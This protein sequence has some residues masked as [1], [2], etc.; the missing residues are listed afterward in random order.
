MD[1]YKSEGFRLVGLA[2]EDAFAPE[3]PS[4]KIPRANR[5]SSGANTPKPRNSSRSSGTR[6]RSGDNVAAA[7]AAAEEVGLKLSSKSGRGPSGLAVPAPTPRGAYAVRRSSDGYV[8]Q[9]SGEV[10]SKQLRAAL[11]VAA[12]TLAKDD[13]AVTQ[14]LSA[15]GAGASPGYVPTA[16]TTTTVTTTTTITTTT[17]NGSSSS[18]TSSSKEVNG[19]SGDASGITTVKPQSLDE[20]AADSLLSSTSTPQTPSP[21]AGSLDGLGRRLLRLGHIIGNDDRVEEVNFPG[22]PFTTVGQFL[23][24]KGSC[25]GVMV[26]PSTVLTAAHCVYSRTRKAWQDKMTFT[27]YRHRISNGISNETDTWPM[28]R[29]SYVHVTTYE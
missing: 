3:M 13:N 8:Y 27:P 19:T 28:G 10:A 25:T 26:G 6:G 9:L 5:R 1:R 2:P 18:V 11:V 17:S 22:Y 15:L 24:S 12:A 20:S 21:V 16:G 7:A 23:F 4:I 29:V 14:A